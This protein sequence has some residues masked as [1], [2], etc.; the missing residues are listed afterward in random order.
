MSAIDFSKVE[1]NS[2]IVPEGTYDVEVEKI[3]YREDK[4]YYNWQFTIIG[5]DDPEIETKYNGR[6]LWACTS[7]KD[8]ALWKL[9]EFLI[10][11]G[12][13]EESLSG[14]FNFEPDEFIGACA[15]AQVEHQ[16]YN[17]KTNSSVKSLLNGDKQEQLDLFK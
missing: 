6:K 11:L 12:I 10:A 13:D 8:N 2:A 4:N 17:N 14:E 1:D 7:L 16:V 9:K 3:E 15:V 5:S